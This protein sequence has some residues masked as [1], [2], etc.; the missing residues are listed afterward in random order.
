MAFNTNWGTAH[1]AAIELAA[2]LATLAPDGIEKVFFTSGGSESVEAAWKIAR[3]FHIANGEP[4]RTRAIARKTAYH[5]LSLGALSLTGIP[6]LKEP[7]GSAAFETIHVSNTNSFRA[8]DAD[9]PEAFGARLLAELEETIERVGPETVAM[10]AAEP[11]QK[12]AGACAAGG[13][14]ERAAGDRGPLRDSAAGG[15]SDLRVR[16][17]R[18]VVRRLSLR[19]RAGS[20]NR[21]QGPDIRVRADGC[22]PRARS[23]RGAV[24]CRGAVLAHGITF[25]GHPLCG[26]S[27]SAI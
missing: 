16:A 3:Q 22:G 10:I 18:R 9:D 19:R 4:Q 14:L 17:G 13:L 26:P 20:D 11:I 6:A 25:A 21:R 1:P 7:F 2:K 5:G 27:R 23:R 24:V 12:P 8:P 15:R